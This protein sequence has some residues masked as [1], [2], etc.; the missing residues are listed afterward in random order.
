MLE[1]VPGLEEDKR[2]DALVNDLNELGYDCH[3]GVLDASHFGV[4]QLR[5]RFILLASRHDFIS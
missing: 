1:N 4:P 2:L 5:R 3:Y